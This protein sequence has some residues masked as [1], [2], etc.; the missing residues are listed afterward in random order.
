MERYEQLQE[1]FIQA[2]ISEIANFMQKHCDE[3][4]ARELCKEYKEEAYDDECE[5]VLAS[6]MSEEEEEDTR[7]ARERLDAEYIAERQAQIIG[8][9]ER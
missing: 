1:I 6:W 9:R 4:P 5:N 3:C 7:E 8:W 2:D